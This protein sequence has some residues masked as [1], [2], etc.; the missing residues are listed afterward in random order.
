M[1]D[2]AT[3][4]SAFIDKRRKR[5]TAQ[6]LEIFDR[7]LESP[8]RR[9]GLLDKPEI[10]EGVDRAKAIFRAK[11]RELATDATETMSLT[12]LDFTVN[13]AARELTSQLRQGASTRE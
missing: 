9:L 2:V 1:E 10:K 4:Y 6:A 12:G 11:I 3:S 7:E 13:D 8:L 5:Y